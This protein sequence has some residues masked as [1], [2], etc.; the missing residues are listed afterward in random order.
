MN[1]YSIFGIGF[2]Y[3]RRDSAIS[4]FWFQGFDSR[5]RFNDYGVQND[6]NLAATGN[7]DAVQDLDKWNISAFVDADSQK[8]VL[9][10]TATFIEQLLAKG[11]Y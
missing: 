11:I 2:R 10:F 7:L 6:A 5:S 9:V 8:R 3:I 4:L 1:V